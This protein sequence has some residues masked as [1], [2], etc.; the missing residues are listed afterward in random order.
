MK[1]KCETH[2]NT[3]TIV[4]LRVSL[5][6]FPNDTELNNTLGDLDNL[7]SLLVFGV[8]SQEGLQAGGKLVEGLHKTR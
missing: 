2:L 7:E 4:N 1:L 8:S 3:E 6:V 5:V